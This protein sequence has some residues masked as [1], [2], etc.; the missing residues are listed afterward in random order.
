MLS[1]YSCEDVSR[2]FCTAKSINEW[3]HRTIWLE[4]KEHHSY[5]FEKND[6]L[7]ISYV[8]TALILEKVEADKLER[9]VRCVHSALDS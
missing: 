2:Q 5:L 1:D 3:R 7:D 6:K 4:I 8:I 9:T